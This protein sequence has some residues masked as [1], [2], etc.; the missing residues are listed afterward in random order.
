MLSLWGQGISVSC[1]VSNAYKTE[2]GTESWCIITICGMTLL[3][4]EVMKKDSIILSMRKSISTE[5]SR[6]RRRKILKLQSLCQE[7]GRKREGERKGGR[8]GGEGGRF[9]KGRRDREREVVNSKCISKGQRTCTLGML[10][11]WRRQRTQ[12]TELLGQELREGATG[13]EVSENQERAKNMV[14]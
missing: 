13:K 4:W 9:R 12:R 11:Q 10:E 5:T 7:R 2:P 6:G 14:M 8:R 3:C 1:C